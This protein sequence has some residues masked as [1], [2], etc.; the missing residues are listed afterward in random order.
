V[1]LNTTSISWPIRSR[2]WQHFELG[3]S[4]LN[5]LDAYIFASFAKDL[6]P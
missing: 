2:N 5:E 1:A 4:N 3:S 6:S